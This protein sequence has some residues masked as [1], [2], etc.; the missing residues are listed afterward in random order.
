VCVCVAVD[1]QNNQTLTFEVENSQRADDDDG[2][3]PVSAGGLLSTADIP[4]SLSG[5]LSPAHIPSSSSGY[6]SST[7]GGLLTPEDV[8]IH[9]IQGGLSVG[10]LQGGARMSGGL[11]STPDDVS[12][13]AS[14]DV[15]LTQ[16]AESP[17]ITSASPVIPSISSGISSAAPSTPSASVGI[18][19]TFSGIPS[20]PAGIPS[21]SSGISSAAPGTPSASSGTPSASVGIPSTFSG[22]PSAPAGIPSTSTDIPSTSSAVSSSHMVG[23]GS[24]VDTEPSSSSSRVATVLTPPDTLSIPVITTDLLIDS[25]APPSPPNSLLGGLM[26]LPNSRPMASL[27]VPRLGLSLDSASSDG[28]SSFCSTPGYS[29]PEVSSPGIFTPEDC[30][31]PLFIPPSMSLSVCLPVCLSVSY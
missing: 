4:T 7:Q 9:S 29:T 1:E 24:C 12:D 15:T 31:S 11:C 30:L 10:D 8:V 21:T 26:S 3:Y 17:A 19:S 27:A 14:L 23:G 28:D 22:I 20:A 5:H 16:P 2:Q 6:G 18:P 13:L 25:E